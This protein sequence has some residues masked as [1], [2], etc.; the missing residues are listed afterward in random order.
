[1]IGLRTMMHMQHKVKSSTA[2]RG[3]LPRTSMLEMQMQDGDT[4][5]DRR[6]G[7]VCLA[8]HQIA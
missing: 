6:V 4:A 1:M 5:I 2:E 7:A 3:A 8:A